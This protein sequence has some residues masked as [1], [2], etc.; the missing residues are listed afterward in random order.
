MP[1]SSTSRESTTGTTTSASIPHATDPPSISTNNRL[2][3][4]TKSSRMGWSDVTLSLV[5]P[6]VGSLL[7]HFTDRW[8]FIFG[9]KYVKMDQHKY[10]ALSTGG[11]QETSL[12]HH[13]LNRMQGHLGRGVR[14]FMGDE[15]EDGERDFG[16]EDTREEPQGLSIQLCRR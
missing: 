15:E 3:D 2:V 16:H 14:R 5:G 9:E 4:R 1:A 8:N 7:D 10:Q 13:M 11:H 12:S 6:I